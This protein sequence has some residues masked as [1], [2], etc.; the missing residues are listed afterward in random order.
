L[1]LLL[2]SQ[3]LLWAIYAPHLLTQRL[4]LLL[5]NLATELIVS[6]AS[7]WELLGKIGRGKLLLAGTSVDTAMERIGALGVTYIP[8]ELADI[9]VAAKLPQH[10]TD[11][12]D[13]VI[14]A[15]G[16]NGSFPIASNDGMFPNYDIEII[17]T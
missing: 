6:H 8:V 16:M 5:R 13:R 10:H 17:W 11:P 7:L 2:D 4:T 12:F 9:V 14:I 3:V 1:K 15:Q